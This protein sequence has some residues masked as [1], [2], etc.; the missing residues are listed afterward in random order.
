MKEEKMLDR[1]VDKC[2]HAVRESDCNPWEIMFDKSL[3]YIEDKYWNKINESLVYYFWT[4][5]SKKNG[6]TFFCFQSSTLTSRAI[7]SY[8]ICDAKLLIDFPHGIFILRLTDFGEAKHF[9]F[10]VPCILN[11]KIVIRSNFIILKQ[12]SILSLIS[13][14]I[15]ALV[16]CKQCSQTYNFLRTQW[17]EWTFLKFTGRRSF[18]QRE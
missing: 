4:V 13:R 7:L 16:D 10:F 18:R 15:C 8:L 17:R 11:E 14:D 5:V 9:E 6:Q 12:L 2:A 1:F 3:V